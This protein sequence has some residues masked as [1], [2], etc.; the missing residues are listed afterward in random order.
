[1]VLL[2]GFSR[3]TSECKRETVLRLHV[4]FSALPT[5]RGMVPR[6]TRSV[7]AIPQS[8][9]RRRFSSPAAHRVTFHF[10]LD[11]RISFSRAS[12]MRVETKSRPRSRGQ[13][14]L[15][16]LQRSIRMVCS[17]HCQRE[18]QFS[19]PQLRRVQLE[20]GVYRRLLLS[21]APLLRT[22]VTQ[23]SEFQLTR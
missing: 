14:K 21:R 6:S 18:L 13:A 5:E 10:L 17:P 4:R 3:P 2:L 15:L 11:S 1:M 16:T 7:R 12:R 22:Q 20:R 9:R 23:S 8:H 19:A